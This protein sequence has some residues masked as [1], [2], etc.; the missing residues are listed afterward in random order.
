MN[1]LSEESKP[2][3]SEADN[4]IREVSPTIKLNL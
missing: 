3:T 2:N 1:S 4:A